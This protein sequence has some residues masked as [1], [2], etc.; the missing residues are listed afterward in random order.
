MLAILRTQV[1]LGRSLRREKRLEAENRALRGD[2]Q[3]RTCPT[4]HG[5][6]AHQPLSYNPFKM[7]AYGVGTEGCF[8]QNG[9]AVGLNGGPTLTTDDDLATTLWSGYRLGLHDGLNRKSDDGVAPEQPPRVL[10][11]HVVL[12]HMRAGCTHGERQYNADGCRRD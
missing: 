2:G 5:G 9:A 6:I 11:R 8:S 1:E 10:D 12:P 4:W 7:I 3:K